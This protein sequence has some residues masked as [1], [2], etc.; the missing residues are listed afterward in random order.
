MAVIEMFCGSM[1]NG[2]S[3]IVN[4]I[5][6]K[7]LRR[8]G[9]I[10][11]NYPLVDEWAITYASRILPPYASE[12]QILD[13]AVEYYERA[14]R[15][16]SVQSCYEF[17]NQVAQQATGRQAET[18]EEWGLQV[19]DEASLYF[20]ARD[21]QRARNNQFI[22]Y[23]INIRKFKVQAIFMTHNSEDI[24]KQI[25]GKVDLVTWCRNM[26][27]R[28]ILGVSLGLFYKQPR[29]ATQSIV[30]GEGTFKGMTEERFTYKLDFDTCDLYDTFKL[31]KDDAHEEEYGLEHLGLHPQSYYKTAAEK[32]R[33]KHQAI[34]ESSITYDYHQNICPGAC[35]V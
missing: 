8:G 11:L 19:F 29:F 24:D 30:N 1:G 6:F 22:E 23:F 28:K 17:A 31:F 18:R 25:R 32:L 26:Q 35:H 21:F 5:A 7:F 33:E 4:S 14:Y 12:Q 13:R 27:K 3:A 34:T 20:N 2:K 9:V 16:G 15:F 10:G